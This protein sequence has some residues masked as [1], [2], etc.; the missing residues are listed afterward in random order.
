MRLLESCAWALRARP[1]PQMSEAAWG[2]LFIYAF[3]PNFESNYLLHLLIAF[4]LWAMVAD[5][6]RNHLSFSE[7]LRN[8]WLIEKELRQRYSSYCYRNHLWTG[9]GATLAVFFF[10]PRYYW[11]FLP[12]M[13]LVPGTIALY[14]WKHTGID[15]ETYQP[16]GEGSATLQSS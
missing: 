11:Y 1:W 6:G 2:F 12:L 4:L 8:R 16:V 13:W 14:R 7:K 3:A 5:W 9:L 10:G 15:E